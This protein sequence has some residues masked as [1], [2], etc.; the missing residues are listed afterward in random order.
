MHI[1]DNKLKLFILITRQLI[2][3]KK[4]EISQYYL[5]GSYSELLNYKTKGSTHLF[6][7]NAQE[8]VGLNS[9]FVWGQSKI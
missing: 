7:T 5:L 8:H 1:P 3:L 9:N 2:Y 4:K 6:V